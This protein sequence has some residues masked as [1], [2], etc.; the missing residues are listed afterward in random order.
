MATTG[1]PS[2]PGTS[3]SLPGRLVRTASALSRLGL[4]DVRGHL[5]ARLDASHVLV[6][7][8][9][10]ERVPP[11]ASL[12]AADLLAV[13]LRTGD[14][15][16]GRWS[17]PPDLPLSLAI[18]RAR[19][20]VQAVA[21]AQPPTA[22]A[23]AAADRPLLPLTHTESA[24]VLPRLP[25]FGRG[26]LLDTPERGSA[27]AGALGDRPLA[28][29]PG[30]GV[31]A[32][33]GGVA[34]AGM[35]CYQVELLAKINQLAA[36]FGAALLVSREDSARISAQKAPPEDFQD[37]FDAV[38]GSRPAAPAV[39]D[40][41]DRSEEGL[42]RRVAAACRLLY[43]HGL[44]EHLEHVSVRLPDLSGFLMS[45]RKHLGQLEPEDLAV[46]G[47]DGAWQR[48]PL[49]PP[50]FLW[51]H[52]DILAARPEVEAIVHTHQSVARALV[53]AGRSVLP[54]ERAGAEWLRQPAPVYA[55]PDLMFGERFRQEALQLLGQAAVFH[56]A[57]HGS[58]FLAQTVE[59]A[60]VAA[61]HY[62]RQARLTHLA[63]QLG[64][65]RPLPEVVLDRP[66]EE[67]PSALTWWRYYLS[68]SSVSVSA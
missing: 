10:G 8:R 23:F 11:P 32:V 65:P 68:E 22:L 9:A 29:L 33:G 16:E 57:S 4:F 36:P 41:A 37:Y 40:P 64:D 31:A 5:S 67:A 25:V 61:I 43:H 63:A 18:F 13:D 56:E 30:Q 52:R 7:P 45:P 3:A 2:H 42:R 66:P 58:D 62:E 44:I 28:L 50:P 34:E 12:S 49:P 6:T 14:V 15:V 46:V 19:P 47:M 53:M 51:F 48:G 35:R 60:T 17:V 27:L 21:L 38:A 1:S 59:E 20:D 26:E 54:L 55:V 39:P 24:L